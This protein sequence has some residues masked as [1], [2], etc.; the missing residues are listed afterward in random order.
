MTK[1]TLTIKMMTTKKYITMLAALFNACL[2]FAACNSEPANVSE[3]METVNKI[4]IEVNG[5]TLTATLEDNTSAEA[6]VEL[7]GE[8]SITVETR[9]YGGFEKVG[10]LPQSLPQND[11]EITTSP[12]DII[13]YTGSAICFYYAQNT[14]D[15]TLL[16]RVDNAEE[17]DF[18]SIYGSGSATF[19]LRLVDTSAVSSVKAD[20]Q[21]VKTET[22]SLNGA[23]AQGR[24]VVVERETLADGTVRTQKVIRK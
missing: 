7:L 17:Y 22:F 1:R 18:E 4:S 10:A 23:R 2:A 8:G 24:G 6:L 16:G 14:W 9:D 5:Y 19:V 21:V 13:L 11:T 3:T 12:G 15:F 20:S